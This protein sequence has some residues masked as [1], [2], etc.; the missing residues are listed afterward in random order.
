M[1]RF[2]FIF[3]FVLVNGTFLRAQ[4]PDSIIVPDTLLAGDTIIFGDTVTAYVAEFY[5]PNGKN[6]T[7]HGVTNRV[8][9]SSH[10]PSGTRIYVSDLKAVNRFGKRVRLRKQYYYVK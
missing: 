8:D 2:Q 3:I 4:P 5:F 9:A 6:M 7:V 10:S 1:R